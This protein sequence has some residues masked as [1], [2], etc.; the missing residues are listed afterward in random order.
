MSKIA[1]K[2]AQIIDKQEVIT[3]YLQVVPPKYAQIALLVETLLDLH[4]HV[5]GRLKVM[6]DRVE[7]GMDGNERKAAP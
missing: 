5:T 7:G 2:A 4:S 3:K 1:P 6:E